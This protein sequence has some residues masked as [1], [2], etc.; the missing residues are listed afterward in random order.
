MSKRAFISHVSEEAEVA[1]CLK[2]ALARD[3]LGFL[4]V[5]VS[6]DGQSIAAGEDWLKSIDEALQGA[7]LVMILCSP[8]SIRRPWINFE[9]GAA[10]MR[11]IP[12]VPLCHAGLTPRDLPMPLSSRQG[13]SLSD[14]AGLQ[15]LYARIAD[16][17]SSAT[18]DRSFNDLARALVKA[19][20][21]LRVGVEDSSE[22]DRTRAIKRRLHEAL[23]HKTYKWRSL[24]SVATA[25]GIS[26]ETAA[27]HLRAD[28]DVRFGKGESG[29]IIVG[30][31]SRVGT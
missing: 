9:A 14:P 5:F 3:F 12:I 4:D 6:S 17:L 16:V 2:T 11:K 25:A 15:R 8:A 1:A 7:D 13:L 10:W 28:P 21:Q 20:E 19:G 27:D 29:A 23:Q 22:L 26:E 18:P 24:E 31:R 30:L